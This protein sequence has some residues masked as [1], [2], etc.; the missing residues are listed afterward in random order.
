MAYAF[1]DVNFIPDEID[2]V[3][4]QEIRKKSALKYMIILLAVFL[5]IGLSLLAF[6]LYTKS[7]INAVVRE[8]DEATAKIAE[9]SDFGKSGYKLGIRLGVVKE[10]LSSRAYYNNLINE[11]DAQT[12][13]NVNVIKIGISGSTDLAI[14][15][16]SE[17]NYT[18][19]A[20]FQRNLLSSSAEYFSDVRLDS[21]KLNKDDGSVDFSLRVVLDK[22]M[23]NAKRN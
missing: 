3:R 19:I 21:A 17:Q 10:L 23:L 6:N 20:L 7:K 1:S 18:P 11:I 16:L 15:A 9:L 5:I 22:G 12:P 14:S 13:Q 4:D 8:T 2:Q